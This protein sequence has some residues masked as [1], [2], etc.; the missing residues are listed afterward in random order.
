MDIFERKIKKNIE[1]MKDIWVNYPENRMKR[2]K[3]AGKWWMALYEGKVVENIDNFLE[4]SMTVLLEFRS[5]TLGN[6][7]L[8]NKLIGEYFTKLKEKYDNEIFTDL[9][10]EEK[11][12]LDMMT[13]MEIKRFLEAKEH[14]M[15]NR[16]LKEA[17]FKSYRKKVAKHTGMWDEIKGEITEYFE[18]EY[19]KMNKLKKVLGNSMMNK[20][21]WDLAKV[22]KKDL[23]DLEELDRIAVEDEKLRYLLEMLGK[24]EKKKNPEFDIADNYYSP[25]KKDLLG[26]HLS[27]DLV[28]L[29]PSELSLVHNKYLRTYFHAKYI[30]NRLSTYLLSDRDEDYDTGDGNRENEGPIILC[31]DTSSSMAGLPEKLAK[32]S[33]LYLLKEAEKQKREIY[34]IAFSADNILREFELAQSKDGIERA[35]E[36]F[37][38]NFYG[39]TDYINPM[40]RSIRLIEKGNYKKADIL[41]ISDGIVKVPKEFNDYMKRVKDRLKFKVYSFI[42]NSKNVENNFSDKVLYYEYK[43]SGNT[44]RGGD[45]QFHERGWM[46]NHG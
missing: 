28:R 2:E 1:V 16:F 7:L 10:G 44:Y 4:D 36:F 11:K 40:N 3:I 19:E 37:K 33:A 38:W 39:G 42:I 13:R 45:Y 46:S 21:G 15:E 17:R 43:K 31:I 20:I 12:A 8:C 5:M 25:N 35:L 26:I 9:V 14:K 6:E 27:N 30:E 18:I 32:A 23:F 41:M 34:V 24:K 22:D 29:L